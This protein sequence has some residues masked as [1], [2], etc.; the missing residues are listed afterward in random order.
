[1]DKFLLDE[2]MVEHIEYIRSQDYSSLY[3]VIK[4]IHESSNSELFNAHSEAI[5]KYFNDFD[6]KIDDDNF[7]KCLLGHYEIKLNPEQLVRNY[8]NGTII[9]ETQ[10]EDYATQL[11]GVAKAEAVEKVLRMLN[12]FSIIE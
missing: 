9:P 1:M 8:Y 3:G 10:S 7:M 4:S 11:I 12:M 5:L 2:Y 6:E